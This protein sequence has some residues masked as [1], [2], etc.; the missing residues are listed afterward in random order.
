MYASWCHWWKY[1]GGKRAEDNYT[2]NSFMDIPLLWFLE[3]V[4]HEKL[5]AFLVTT[6]LS[7]RG[8]LN[9]YRLDVMVW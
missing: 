6:L 5:L 1:C 7:G 2:Q 3:E 8:G 4:P 9:V